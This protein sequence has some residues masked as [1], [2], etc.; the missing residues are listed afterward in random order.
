MLIQQLQPS[1][2]TLVITPAG[3]IRSK[4][5][6]TSFANEAALYHATA[7]KEQTAQNGQ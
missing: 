2:I 3:K 1:F 7:L 4:Y 5:V 6:V